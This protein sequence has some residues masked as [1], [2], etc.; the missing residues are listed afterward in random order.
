MSAEGSGERK[1]QCL[2]L[3]PEPSVFFLFVC[4]FFL[5]EPL[6][7]WSTPLRLPKAL[8]LSKEQMRRRKMSPGSSVPAD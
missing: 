3:F 8:M 2:G 1:I 5:S 6:A 4:L 7:F